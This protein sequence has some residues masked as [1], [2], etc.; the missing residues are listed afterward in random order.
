VILWTSAIKD[1]ETE[2]AWPGADLRAWRWALIVEPRGIVI[3]DQVRFG[4]GEWGAANKYIGAWLS[5]SWRFGFF[6]N[7]HDGPHHSLWLG[8]VNIGWMRDAVCP[9]CEPA[10]YWHHPD[11]SIAGW[12]ERILTAA[13][14]R[15]VAA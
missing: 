8:C 1:Q 2:T 4:D 6:H 7:Y 11:N 12:V 10:P 5:K 15:E 9:V 3:E 13:M 14:G